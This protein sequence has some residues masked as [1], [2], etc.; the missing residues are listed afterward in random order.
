MSVVGISD[1]SSHNSLQNLSFDGIVP[2]KWKSP[3]K[4]AFPFKWTFK[5]ASSHIYSINSEIHQQIIHY[6][7]HDQTHFQFHHHVN[8]VPNH[9]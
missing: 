2:S 6:L 1:N 7:T 3:L 4:G 5:N 8:F 9:H